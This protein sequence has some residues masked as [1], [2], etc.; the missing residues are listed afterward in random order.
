MTQHYNVIMTLDELEAYAA[1]MPAGRDWAYE[2]REA[3]VVGESV[4]LVLFSFAAALAGLF[5]GAWLV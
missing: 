3:P 2:P 1:N 4:R 5:V